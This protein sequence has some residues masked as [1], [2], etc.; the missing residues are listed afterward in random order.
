MVHLMQGQAISERELEL[1]VSSWSAQQFAGFCN[2]LLFARMGKERLPECRFTQRT[3][4]PDGGIDA[5]AELEV[6]GETGYGDGRRGVAYVQYKMRDVTAQPRARL[7]SDLIAMAE[8]EGRKLAA[9]QQK[10]DQYL[11]F[12]NVG[13]SLRHKEKLE[14]SIRKGCP[15]CHDLIIKA[16]GAGDLSVWANNLPHVRAAFFQTSSFSTLE[17][18]E[19]EFQF[20]EQ[21]PAEVPLTGRDRELQLLRDA[22]DDESIRII[23][24]VGPHG[25]GKTRMLLEGLREH[26]TRVVWVNDPTGEAAREL[27]GLLS[28]GQRV[29]A[30][31]DNLE[32]DRRDALIS[33]CPA[34]PNLKVIAATSRSLPE[35]LG[36]REGWP[37]LR[38]SPEEPSIV[39]FPLGP[40]TPQDSRA[41]LDLV[42]TTMDTPLRELLLF[43]A[44]GTPAALLAAARYADSV[45]DGI[46]PD[47]WRRLGAAYES[48]LKSALDD[49]QLRLLGHFSVL[50]YVKVGGQDAGELEALADLFGS[51]T[52]GVHEYRSA[53]DELGAAGVLIGHG[54]YARVTPAF[55]A[56]YLAGK[57]IRGERDRLLA[58]MVKFKDSSLVLRLLRRLVELISYRI[59]EASDFVRNLLAPNGPMG[60]FEHLVE[61]CSWVP[62]L[63][64]GDPGATLECLERVLGNCDNEELR[65]LSATC[66]SWLVQGLEELLLD[67][68]S[69]GGAIKLIFR[70]A[71]AARGHAFPDRGIVPEH[72]AEKTGRILQEI[73]HVGQPDLPLGLSEKSKIFAGLVEQCD[74]TEGLVSLAQV[75]GSS[76]T[77]PAVFIRRSKELPRFEGPPR[78]RPTYH[79]IGLY[80]A[81]MLEVLRK[82]ERRAQPGSRHEIR[83]HFMELFLQRL[84]SSYRDSA[85][86]CLDW[87]AAGVDGSLAYREVIELLDR[88]D[89]MLRYLQ[90]VAEQ[91]SSGDDVKQWSLGLM[92]KISRLEQEL[93]GSGFTSRLK[94]AVG[95]LTL[96]DTSQLYGR[97]A[98]SGVAPALGEIEQLAGEA[99]A[100]PD[101][102]DRELLNWLLG[103]EAE[104]GMAFFHYLGRADK[105]RIWL[106]E[107]EK[108]RDTPMGVHALV[109]YLNGMGTR[110][111]EGL[112]GYLEEAPAG[113]LEPLIVAEVMLSLSYSDEAMKRLILMCNSTEIRANVL[114][115]K[116]RFGPWL[117]EMPANCLVDV[118]KILEAMAWD[119]DQAKY[120][121][122]LDIIETRRYRRTEL[123]PEVREFAWNLLSLYEPGEHGQG[124]GDYNWDAL[125]RYLVET[126]GDY[127]RGLKLL[128]DTI[129]RSAKSSRRCFPIDS[130]RP[131]QL[132]QCLASKNRKRLL[133]R[134]ISLG[135]EDSDLSFLLSWDLKRRINLA[136]EPEGRRKVGARAFASDLIWADITAHDLL[137]LS[138]HDI[139]T[140]RF[141]AGLL[142][143]S[144]KGFWDMAQAL[145]KLFPEDED[146]KKKLLA[147]LPGGLI[148]GPVSAELSA[149]AGYAKKLAKDTDHPV[150]REWAKQS[151]KYLSADAGNELVWEYDLDVEDF[152][153]MLKAED[154]SGRR[155]AISRILRELPLD[156]ARGL[157]SLDDIIDALE[158]DWV[159]LPEKKRR[160]LEFAMR[161]WKNAS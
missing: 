46:E 94:R 128:A 59:A 51:G 37:T 81:E 144:M 35:E 149:R 151:I 70:L 122:L 110:D 10:P 84:T 77:M 30:V 24:L 97:G 76:L 134:L 152:R 100:G 130:T 32:P 80:S 141:V 86:E 88:L 56:R 108:Q 150:V 136:G 23:L 105:G 2:T 4:V 155:W 11:Y 146:L 125:A 34:A 118:L 114:A 99:C 115:E 18:A 137:E 126:D 66:H 145:I 22:L 65:S 93:R 60:N 42:P 106:E 159:E 87:I 98:Q 153:G 13:L 96:A 52:N 28:A 124:S 21:W 26:E 62:I 138:K 29:I 45:E 36:A 148:E 14:S 135:L 9:L 123:D 64:C 1:L 140:A 49:E 85:E 67:K 90:S 20:A 69:A 158:G 102:L 50:T 131:S 101:L 12:T 129:G 113:G 40:L 157:L 71:G 119:D 73:F 160:S 82:L 127:D 43:H 6:T 58:A 39:F 16:Y 55:L 109:S 132:W 143:A 74:S 156:K 120:S 15:N 133:E 68:T 47:F 38:F 19:E 27:R 63:A 117:E 107:L 111:R 154:P 95:P 25:I 44:E 161:Y 75:A 61:N 91:D 54:S 139:E 147:A 83:R 33:S 104:R 92:N 116:M 142:D 7:I 31:F 103:D 53:M 79:E 121:H 78:H 48:K 41:L 112:E 5:V 3:N 57:T 8:A 17:M 89:D 72:R